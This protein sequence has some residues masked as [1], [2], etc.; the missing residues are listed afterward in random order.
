MWGKKQQ[1]NYM[2][3][4]NDVYT[5]IID[6]SSIFSSPRFS[7]R[8]I[9]VFSFFNKW[10]AIPFLIHFLEFFFFRSLPN[11]CQDLPTKKKN[12]FVKFLSRVPHIFDQIVIINPSKSIRPTLSTHS[13]S[14]DSPYMFLEIYSNV[15]LEGILGFLGAQFIHFPLTFWVTI[16]EYIY[17]YIDIVNVIDIASCL[18][19]R[20]P[21]I[22]QYFS[23]SV[24]QLTKN[25][26]PL[27]Y[28]PSL[29]PHTQ[30]RLKY[31]AACISL[32]CCFTASVQLL[33]RVQEN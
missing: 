26:C 2:W 22:F 14:M 9:Y 13:K 25:L 21:K 15:K 4:V 17:I 23:S 29:P 28:N 33:K 7:C 1:E 18:R 16:W 5:L 3:I 8:S 31:T 19:L 11:L 24:K 12:I 20:M 6:V 10:A 32:L 27:K 30:R